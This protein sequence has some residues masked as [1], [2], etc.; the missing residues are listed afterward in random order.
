MMTDL[1]PDLGK[2]TMKSKKISLQIT[3]GI[4]SDWSV[5]IVILHGL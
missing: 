1:L 4:R 3:G 5:P 2:P